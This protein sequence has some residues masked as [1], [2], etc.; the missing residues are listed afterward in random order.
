MQTTGIRSPHSMTRADLRTLGLASIG[1]ALEFYD[2]II[3]V[4]FTTVI[5]KLFFAAGQPDWIRQ[6]QTF[7]IFAAGYLARPLG[8]LIMAHFGDKYGRKRIF[9]LS[10]LLM[11]I[12]TLLI[13]C[14]PTYRSIGAA[15]PLLLL[16]MRVL[17]GAA[18]G[19]EAPG[20]WV[21]VAE[22]AQRERVG[23]A[24]GLLTCGL[25]LG[26]LL[27]SLM[28]TGMNL[29]FTQA[30]MLAGA[31]RIP[32]LVGGVFAFIAMW[33]RRWLE[34]TPV[35]EE[36]KRRAGLSRQLPLRIVIGSHGKAIAASLVCT[37]ML[38]A[39]IVVVVLMT[40]TLLQKLFGLTPIQAQT[41]NLATTAALCVSTVLTGAA[42]D[43]FG[44]RRVTVFVLLL[45]VVSTCALYMTAGQMPLLLLP[46]SV[47]AGIGT[48]GVVATPIVMVRSFPGAVRFS[49][50]SFSYN[51]AYAVFGGLTP[52]LVL[53]LAH[54]N[55][56]GPAYYVAVAAIAGL[57]ATLV[58]PMNYLNSS[59]NAETT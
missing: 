56:V 25:T 48:G 8:G 1:G 24:V 40:P 7:G 51:V 55:R 32:F 29:A 34:E 58:A 57:F 30:Q 31:W 28:A 26:I 27:G 6:A 47:L 49:G 33:L 38:T 53:S 52:L 14:L 10:V 42:T 21:F 11:A 46:L 37:W 15:A 54:I 18:I 44:I 23:F 43:R 45:L 2:F 39:A 3:F 36:M 20:A 35:F 41:A 59:P 9:M 19:G 17:Q 22:H 50:V 12:P 5:G 13:G 4:F 16:F